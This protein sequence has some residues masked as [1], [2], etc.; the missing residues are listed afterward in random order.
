MRVKLYTLPLF[1]V[2]A[3]LRGM[4]I[5]RAIAQAVRGNSAMRR[6]DGYWLGQFVY[7]RPKLQLSVSVF[8]P[9]LSLT[10]CKGTVPREQI[11]LKENSS[12]FKVQC[13]SELWADGR[14]L[15]CVSK[16]VQTYHCRQNLLG[17]CECAILK[18]PTFM[19][20]VAEPE[21]VELKLF[22]GG[23]AGAGG[24]E[25]ILGW[26]SRSRSQNY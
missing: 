2:K 11:E 24:A 25:I 8:I 5:P 10:T 21:P 9:I 18:N 14:Q 23:G 1:Q 3:S 15:V 12:A 13:C 20:S 26:W 6:Q 19:T 22:W 7:K 17:Y 4:P 16:Q